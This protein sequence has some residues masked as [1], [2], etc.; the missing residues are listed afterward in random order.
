ML[1]GVVAVVS[2]HG[3]MTFPK[4]R[5]SLDGAIA[6]WT[7]WA[8]PCDETHKGGDCAITFCENGQVRVQPTLGRGSVCVCVLF[9]CATD[10]CDGITTSTCNPNLN[11]RVSPLDPPTIQN[12]EG[13]CPLSAHKPGDV[14]AL[15]ASNGQSCYWFSNGCT[16]GCDKCDGT[17]NHVG[18]GFQRF[19]YKASPLPIRMRKST[20]N[21]TDP[22]WPQTHA[23]VHHII[24]VDGKHMLTRRHPQ[25]IATHHIPHAIHTPH[26]GCCNTIKHV[27]ENPK[28]NQLSETLFIAP[29]VLQSSWILPPEHDHGGS[30]QE[31]CDHPQSLEPSAGRHGA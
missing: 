19:T 21:F 31:E 3:A 8:Y 26:H 10:V 30:R 24:S 22:G 15:N 20:R 29:I 18:H 25:Y 5:N 28:K 4:P 14:E 6:P 1:T 11:S 12:C 7:K 17:N 2:G 13:S 9:V 23:R 16:I 27:Q